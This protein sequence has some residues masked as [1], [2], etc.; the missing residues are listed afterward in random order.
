MCSRDLK[1][2]KIK[3]IKIANI[4]DVEYKK[5]DKGIIKHV[6]KIEEDKCFVIRALDED[7]NIKNYEFVGN[8]AEPLEHFANNLKLFVEYAKKG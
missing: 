2:K 6:N 7:G 1:D 5:F 8:I 4:R 3:K